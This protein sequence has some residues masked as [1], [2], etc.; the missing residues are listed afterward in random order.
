[1]TTDRPLGS[2]L[3]A[4]GLGCALALVSR[5]TTANDEPT[6]EITTDT[7]AYC[8]QLHERIETMLHST[9]A[10]PPREVMELAIEGQRMCD[11]GLPRGGILRLRRALFIM[12]HPSQGP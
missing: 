1:M 6:V 7:A 11:H 9:T 12:T 10:V 4:L 8:G 3:P 5:T 2:I